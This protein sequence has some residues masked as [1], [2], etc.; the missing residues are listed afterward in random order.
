[1]KS[2]KFLATVIEQSDVFNVTVDYL[3]S[4]TTSKKGKT[5]DNA[6][7]SDL[8]DLKDFMEHND[9]S[10]TYGGEELTETEKNSLKLLWR[11]YSGNVKKLKK[12]QKEMTTRSKSI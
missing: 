9:G 7:E 3:L 4:K 12:Q 8:K 10:M 1:M 5:P 2:I 11:K 6:T